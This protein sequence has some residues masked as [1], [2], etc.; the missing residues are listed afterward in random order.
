MLLVPDFAVREDN[1]V[2]PDLRD[3]VDVG[4]QAPVFGVDDVNAQKLL[5]GVDLEGLGNLLVRVAV[6]K[7]VL[8]LTINPQ[9]T[10]AADGSE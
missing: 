8:E 1:V 10:V 4:N 5:A 2:L 7:N 6:V 3:R 9:L